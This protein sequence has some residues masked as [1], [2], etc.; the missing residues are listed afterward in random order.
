MPADR[1]YFAPRF[2][3]RIGGHSLS[4]DVSSQVTS[5]SYESNLDMAD[6][7]QFVLYNQNHR[8]TDS[9][10]FEIG[11][12]VELYMGYGAN[13][14]PMTLGEI[15]SVQPTFPQ[16]G[17]PTLNVRGYDLSY[18]LR[19]NSPTR[20]PF[21]AV[22][23]SQIAEAIARDA[24]L[25]AEVDPTSLVHEHLLQTE[26]DLPFLQRRADCNQFDA[27]VRWDKLFFKKRATQAQGHQRRIVEPEQR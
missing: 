15:A 2:E 19:Q 23:D 17:V 26:A 18:R 11:Q 16:S 1:P 5:V 3:L 24:Q 12:R 13:L 27:Y 7:F 14:Q 25:K 20:P 10:L 21:K 6:M 22:T 4:P 8:F 9:D